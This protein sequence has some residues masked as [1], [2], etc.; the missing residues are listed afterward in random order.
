MPDMRH[1]VRCVA[2]CSA[3]ANLPISAKL[4]KISDADMLICRKCGVMC[5][6]GRCSDSA[7]EYP[8]CQADV[9]ISAKMAEIVV[10]DILICRKCGIMSGLQGRYANSAAESQA[11]RADVPI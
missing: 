3:W 6:P 11:C 4:A 7:A 9:P 5:L 10:V 1:N 2:E 8:A